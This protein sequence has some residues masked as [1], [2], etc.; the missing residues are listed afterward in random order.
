[1]GYEE[2]LGEQTVKTLLDIAKAYGIPGRHKMR[3][4][5]LIERIIQ[6]EQAESDDD[7][8]LDTSQGNFDKLATE[9]AAENR[10]A[11]RRVYLVN[12]S[13]GSIV[14]FRNRL[15]GKVKS[16]KILLNDRNGN[17]R[18]ETGYGKIYAVEYDDII[19]VKIGNRWP[20]GVYNLLKGLGTE[21]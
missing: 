19:W 2:E 20:R 11:V 1:M 4:G 16:A 14:A 13:E 12:A 6:A 8:V 3:K 5:V 15:T 17:M 10:L 7:D 21:T 9:N 18:L